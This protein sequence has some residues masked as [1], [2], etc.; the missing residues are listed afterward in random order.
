MSLPALIASLS[1]VLVILWDSFETIVLPRRVTRK[2]RIARAFYRITWKP[3]SRAANLFRP[4]NRRDPASMDTSGG[5]SRQLEDKR[6]G[7]AVIVG[8]APRS[9]VI[10]EQ[11]YIRG[12]SPEPIVN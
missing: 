9:R 8:D 4:A 5:L 10:D 1:L 3:W 7:A 2:F 11:C 6:V 12:A